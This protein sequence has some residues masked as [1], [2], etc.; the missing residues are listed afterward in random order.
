MKRFK[1]K[2]KSIDQDFEALKIQ[3]LQHPDMGSS[4]GSNLYK[5]RMPSSNKVSGKSGGF[6]VITYLIQQN[7]NETTIVSLLSTTNRKKIVLIKQIWRNWQ[8]STETKYTQIGLT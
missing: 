7:N 5:V 6:R 2:F 3:L 4:L 1:K 8:N